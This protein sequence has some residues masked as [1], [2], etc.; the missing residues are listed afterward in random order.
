MDLGKFNEEL[1]K[2]EDNRYDYWQKVDY[3]NIVVNFLVEQVKCLTEE[4]IELKRQISSLHG[5]VYGGGM[6]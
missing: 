6:R 1:K 3:L 4:N 5:Q 2:I